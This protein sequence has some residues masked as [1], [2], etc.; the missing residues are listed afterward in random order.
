MKKILS[1]EEI[2]TG[3]PYDVLTKNFENELGRYD[4]DAVALL[5][6]ED[7]SWKSFEKEMAE[8]A[9]DNGLML[10][11]KADQGRVA[12]IHSGETKCALY[13]VG[14]PFIAAQIVSIDVRASFLV[15]FRVTIY[16][17]ENGKGA[18]IGFRKP[19]SF[20]AELENS[21]LRPFGELLDGKINSI[22]KKIT[23]NS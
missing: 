17:K 13:L 3:I 18:F 12:S 8:M 6:Q 11:F 9:G 7:V 21:D 1:F 14:N 23:S 20:L 10:F 16:E 4:A 5:I 19:S 15:P 22:M 2:A